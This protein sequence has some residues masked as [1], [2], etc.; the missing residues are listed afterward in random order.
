MK[1]YQRSQAPELARR[2]SAPRR[3]IQVV[4]GPQQTG[5]TTLVQ[6]VTEK[7]DGPVR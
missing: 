3:F 4:A 6:Q 7:L 1:N 2:L 5:K